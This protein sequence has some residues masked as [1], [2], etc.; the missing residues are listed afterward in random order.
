[1]AHAARRKTLREKQ[2]SWHMASFLEVNV[3]GC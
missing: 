1:M 2:K 3:E